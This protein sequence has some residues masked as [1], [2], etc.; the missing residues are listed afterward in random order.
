MEEK[1]NHGAMQIKKNDINEAEVVLP[2][3]DCSELC[4]E[5]VS[6]YSADQLR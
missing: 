1:I 2:C 3:F 5:Q 6:S 4:C